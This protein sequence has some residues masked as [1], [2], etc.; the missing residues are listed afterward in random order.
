MAPARNQGGAPCAVLAPC[1]PRSGTL[2]GICTAS[3]SQKR[4]PRPVRP[5][6][7]PPQ[8]RRLQRTCERHSTWSWDCRNAAYSARR[9]PAVPS[10]APPAGPPVEHGPRRT[11][12]PPDNGGMPKTWGAGRHRIRRSRRSRRSPPPTR[13]RRRQRGSP[14]KSSRSFQ[15]S[16]RTRRA[17]AQV[18]GLRMGLACIGRPSSQG[19]SRRPPLARRRLPATLPPPRRTSRPLCCPPAGFVAIIGRPNA[20][21]STLMNALLGQALSIVTPKAQT[22]RHRVL[23]IMSEPR[24]QVGAAAHRPLHAAHAG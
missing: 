2:H 4:L 6:P 8:A 9:A 12:G 11:A 10:P 5:E 23:G 16:Q 19:C 7:T 15:T 1:S 17:T 18:G 13:R 20:G 22:T 3:S 21:K 24:Y 14:R